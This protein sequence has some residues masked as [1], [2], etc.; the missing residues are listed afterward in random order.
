MFSLCR[1]SKV[2]ER[3]KKAALKELEVYRTQYSLYEKKS[4]HDTKKLID[5]IDEVLR[6]KN[7]NHTDLEHT[8]GVYANYLTTLEETNGP[9]EFIRVFNNKVS[10]IE[11]VHTGVVE[12]N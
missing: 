9:V 5:L 2:A 1:H 7:D 12:N 10:P 11:Y 8:R 4:A 6:Y 3:Q